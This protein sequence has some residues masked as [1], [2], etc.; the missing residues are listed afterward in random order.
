M[1]I[2]FSQ[3][4]SKKSDAVVVTIADGKLLSTGKTVDGQAAN[5]LT[6][7]IKATGFK[8]RIGKRLHV[9]GVS[10]VGAENAYI[11][12]LGNMS[13]LDENNGVYA[14]RELSR[15]FNFY[16]AKKMDVMVDRLPKQSAETL[17]NLLAF[18]AVLESYQFRS[19][20]TESK[21]AEQTLN[22]VVDNPKTAE[23]AFQKY[24]AIANGEFL[25]RDLG[26]EPP[27]SLYPE[28]FAKRI[29]DEFKGSDVRVRVL[30]EKELKKL[31]MGSMLAVGQG[32]DRPPR[33]VVMEY[34]N[35][36][37]KKSKPV[38]FVGK[39]ITFDSGGISIKSNGGR[40]MK[41]DMCGA[42]AV[43]GAMKALSGRGAKSHVVGI[44]ALAEN[45]PSSKSY[46]P[47]DVVK[48]MSG[49]TVEVVNTDAEGRLVL[50]DALTYVQKFHDPRC[51]VDL[52]TL[53]GAIVSALGDEFAGLFTNS[54][55]LAEMLNRSGDMVEQKMWRMP[56]GGRAALS[57]QSEIADLKHTGGR[58]GAS[59][60]ASFLQAFVDKGRPWAHLDIAGT[61]SYGNTATGYGV[62]LLD[63]FVSD[64]F[65]KKKAPKPK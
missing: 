12:G 11:L 41:F 63:R 15:M 51:I 22:F 34:N 64:N 55:D 6:R 42:G 33:L 8:G 62:R 5:A 60:A 43:V 44:V 30:D 65:E 32:S 20:K 45:M 52:A 53:T 57:L 26:H 24:Q 17:A 49:K 23:K 58:P 4:P 14:G 2:T 29:Q 38:A 47:D 16:G 19:Y 7:A 21:T 46:R 27:N 31:G 50:N 56:V 18:G 36:G 40:G 39:G 1:K 48:S 28:S 3:K 35:T 9:A 13:Y 25:T 59:V 10:G 37:D 61:A 54:S